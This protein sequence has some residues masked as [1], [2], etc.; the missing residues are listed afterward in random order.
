MWIPDY[1]EF[2]EYVKIHDMVYLI[3]KGHRYCKNNT[4]GSKVYWRC[5]GYQRY[6]CR[7]RA[8]TQMV[9]GYDMA[10]VKNIVHEHPF[11]DIRLTSSK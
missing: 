3:T 8:V 6:G 10:K 11:V 5:A 4:S 2:A 1:T 9:D 7:G